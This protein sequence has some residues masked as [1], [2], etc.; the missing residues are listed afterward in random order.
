[1]EF[2]EVLILKDIQEL[3]Y[4]E[5]G[6]IMNIPGG[7]VKSRLFRAREALR[8]RLKRKLGDL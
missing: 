3:S 7:T 4:E 1:V 6:A 8:E 2:R 5:I